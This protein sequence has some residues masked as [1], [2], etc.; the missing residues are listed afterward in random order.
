MDS[1]TVADR[2]GAAVFGAKHHLRLGKE[3]WDITDAQGFKVAT[4]VHERA[5]ARDL[6]HQR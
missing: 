2:S 3:H 6:H 5:H 4:L 1:Y